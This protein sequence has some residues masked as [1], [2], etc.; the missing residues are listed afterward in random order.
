MKETQTQKLVIEGFESDTF[1]A[2]LQYIYT[3]NIENIEVDTALDL[4]QAAN[5]YVA[6]DKLI[7]ICTSMVMK[8]TDT[9]NV[10][11][12]YQIARMSNASK[13]QQFCLGMIGNDY[14]SVI[15]SE[16]FE[17]LDDEVKDEIHDFVK[18]NKLQTL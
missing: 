4:L 9:E 6:D 12:V 1:L 10:G 16:V 13:L 14:F 2:L 8:G 18:S 15:K 17:S 11:Y 7:D 3:D 5:M